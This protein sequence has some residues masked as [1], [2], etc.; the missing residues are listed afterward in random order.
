[1]AL[2]DSAF[3]A[4]G[5]E[6]K[7]KWAIARDEWVDETEATPRVYPRAGLL[8]LMSDIIIEL[9]EGYGDHV[10]AAVRSSY[11]T[12]NP[13]I[14]SDGF[15]HRFV[16]EYPQLKMASDF[17]HRPEEK[18]SGAMAAHHM[19]QG[20]NFLSNHA[21]TVPAEERSKACNQLHNLSECP[22]YFCF[23]PDKF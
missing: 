10:F 6:D 21:D 16:K 13:V 15:A 1:V 8:Q 22:T 19:R 3:A 17:Q 9:N 18:D 5:D 23:R 2:G 12:P 14:A 11:K 7:H 20:V 4:L